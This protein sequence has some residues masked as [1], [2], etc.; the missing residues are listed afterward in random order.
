MNAMCAELEAAR[1]ALAQQT[2]ARIAAMDQLRHTDRLATV[3]KL[4]SGLAHEMGTP[5]NVVS[6]RAKMIAT[7]EAVGDEAVECARI[8]VAQADR[9]TKIIR[10]LLDFSRRRGPQKARIDVQSIARQTIELLVPLARKHNVSL[11]LEGDEHVTADIDAGQIQQALTN[12]IVNAVQAMTA[13]GE[14]TVRLGRERVRPPPDIG[15][16]EAD[17]ARIDVHDTGRGI[18]GGDLPRIFEPFFTTKQVGEGTG[19]G[20][21]VAFG[22]V[23]EHKGW[24]AV[25]SEVQKGSVFSIYLP[26]EART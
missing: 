2:A 25:E 17:H 13:P 23:R 22:L 12:L 16:P 5:L 7:G 21:S 8:V 6:G 1:E 18:T 3:G 26:M 20:L 10:Q 15:G 9:I 24:I 11:L 14:V 19:L 4:A